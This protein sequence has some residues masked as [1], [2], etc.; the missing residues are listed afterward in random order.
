[1]PTATFAGWGLAPTVAD[2]KPKAVQ[3]LE[4][5]HVAVTTRAAS[6][7]GLAVL[8][9]DRAIRTAC[10]NACEC[11]LWGHELKGSPRANLVRS[12]SDCA[13]DRYAPALALS[14]INGLHPGR[15]RASAVIT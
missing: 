7:I 9:D 12:S 15:T 8:A 13:S 4:A 10:R 1:M 2:A 5:G 14:V 3:P 6:S 11:Q